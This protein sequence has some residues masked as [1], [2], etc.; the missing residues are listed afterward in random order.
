MKW[1]VWCCTTSCL[2]HGSH[3]VAPVLQ[4]GHAEWCKPRNNTP[5]HVYCVQVKCSCM[6]HLLREAL[7]LSLYR[8]WPIW[9]V[10]MWSLGFFLYP[11][12]TGVQV[13]CHSLM[14]REH[15]NRCG[16][17][18]EWR[19]CNSLCPNKCTNARFLDARDV[20][21][22]IQLKQKQTGE[23]QREAMS[24]FSAVGS[25]SSNCMCVCV[26]GM[27]WKCALRWHI[28]ISVHSVLCQC[29]TQAHAHTHPQTIWGWR[30]DGA[31]SGHCR[32]VIPRQ[33]KNY[34][35]IEYVTIFRRSLIVGHF[36]IL[37]EGT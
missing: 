23:L 29:Y 8:G 35:I 15:R 11:L 5:V 37:M 26:D 3:S 12:E 1:A 20:W 7:T 14:I 10:I 30:T 32:E 13:F 22:M 36:E 25:R 21:T 9:L 27:N 6:V 16:V 4:Q 34:N 33:Y 2:M 18:P 28:H 19:F 17:S 24:T 31:K